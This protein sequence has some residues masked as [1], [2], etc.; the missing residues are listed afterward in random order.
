MTSFVDAAI[1]MYTIGAEHPLKA[2]CR[3]VIRQ[4]KEGRVDATTS[5]EVVQEILHRYRSVGRPDLARA[6]SQDVMDTFAPLLPVTHAVMRR[7]SVLVDRYPSL[8]SR[9]LV[10]VATCIIEGIETII[11]PDAG[12]DQVTEIRRIDPRE[13]AVAR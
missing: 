13:F 7:V 12:F 9:D 1:F 11:T 6:L 3:A 4:I 2:P 8:S 5:V 10:H